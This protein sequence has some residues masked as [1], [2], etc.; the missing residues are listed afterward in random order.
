M[1]RRACVDRGLAG[2]SSLQAIPRRARPRARRSPSRAAPRPRHPRSAA[3][4]AALRQ[5]AAEPRRPHARPCRRAPDGRSSSATARCPST[6][7][8]DGFVAGTWSVE[9]GRVRLEPF[10]RSRGA[11]RREVEDEAARL[12]AFLRACREGVM[13]TGSRPDE[14]RIGLGCMRLDPDDAA[15]TIAAA[16]EAGITVFD[17][18]RA[19][20]GNE[21]APRSRAPQRARSADRDEGRHGGT[22]R[23]VGSGRSREGD[24]GRLRGEPRTRST[25]SRS[26][27]TSCIRRI[28]ARRGARP[29]AR[30]RG[31]STTASSRGSASATSTARSWTR[32][33][34]SRRS[35]RCR[36]GSAVLDDRALRGGVVDRCAELGIAVSRTRRSAGRAGRRQARRGTR[37][38][39]R[40]RARAGA[41]E[42]E[43]ALAWLLGLGAARRRHSRRTNARDRALV[44]A[45][46]VARA[47]SRDE[48]RPHRA[49]SAART[50]ATKVDGDI[51]L[52]MGVPGA[53]KSRVAAE[54]RRRVAT[55]GCNRDERGGSL[56]ELA[57]ALDDALASG[58]REVVLDN[59]YL[60]RAA[61]QL[62]RRGGCAPRRRRAVHLARHAARAGAGQPRR[63]TARAVRRRFRLRR[64]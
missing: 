3:P 15:E 55:S 48:T 16:V 8:V 44:G 64:S 32:R 40:W 53:G 21:A 47:R 18:A 45:R 10:A 52:V 57:D 36:S 24:P 63:A 25:G 61:A 2:G 14:L 22:E 56:R 12:E 46:R 35:R 26:T 59:T 11:A 37:R 4:P 49:D 39:S 43:V 9:G 51:V 29:C 17:T 58:A 54:L 41:T 19:Y 5:P 13:P 28:H 62:R 6:F 34:A 60:T 50:P 38:S 42:A 27:S 20:E 7:L 33:R 31:S 1:A 30:S 23:R